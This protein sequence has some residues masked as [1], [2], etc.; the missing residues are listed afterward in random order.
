MAIVMVYEWIVHNVALNTGGTV[1]GFTFLAA[2][3][4]L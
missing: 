1:S 2:V 4:E 3:R